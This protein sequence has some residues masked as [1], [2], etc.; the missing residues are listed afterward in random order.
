MF[1]GA[2]VGDGI[3]STLVYW[4]NERNMITIT[5]PI[6]KTLGFNIVN[7]N[8]NNMNSVTWLDLLTHVSTIADNLDMLKKV[9]TVGGSDSP[10]G[11]CEFVRNYLVSSGMYY[12][13]ANYYTSTELRSSKFMYS[14][15]NYATLACGLETLTNQ[16]LDELAWTLMKPS[17]IKRT[18]YF[19][20]DLPNFRR[21]AANYY[22]PTNSTWAR[23]VRTAVPIYSAYGIQTTAADLATLG[24]WLLAGAP[25]NA[26]TKAMM[27][28]MT[29]DNTGEPGWNMT[30]GGAWTTTLSDG[31]RIYG[32]DAMGWFGTEWA[33]KEFSLSGGVWFSMTRNLAIAF[34]MNSFDYQGDQYTWIKNAFDV[35]TYS[36]LATTDA[37]PVNCGSHTT[38]VFCDQD[39]YCKWIVP[40]TIP[41]AGGLCVK[42]AANPVHILGP[43]A[44][45]VPLN[46]YV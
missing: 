8:M 31:S 2:G 28:M 43:S 6:S 36:A 14:H 12:S 21:S 44:G 33:P 18:S 19:Y 23:V 37:M 22:K 40:W 34:I 35:N 7:P 3:I 13:E 20:Q 11:N 24:A 5:D 46:Q 45:V 16:T 29:N 42:A 32:Y 39:P 9:F 4:Y 1:L 26:T 38:E 41:A 27:T 17:G 30:M 25:L 15:M 10:M